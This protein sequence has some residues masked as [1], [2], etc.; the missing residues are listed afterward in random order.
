MPFP[1]TGKAR[2]GLS[3]ST[4]AITP[5]AAILT[6]ANLHDVAQPVPLIDAIAATA[7]GAESP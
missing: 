2:F 1:R 7:A 4:R 6:G 5:I 3:P